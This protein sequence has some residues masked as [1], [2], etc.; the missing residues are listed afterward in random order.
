M[1]MYN[2]VVEVDR[3]DAADVDA[4]MDQLEHHHPAV[5]ISP[6]GWLEARISLPAETLTQACT[7]A[8]LIVEAAT[9]A[10]AI[11]CEVMTEDEFDAREGFEPVPDLLGVTEAAEILGVSRQRIDQLV[12]AGKI[13]SIPVGARSR[14]Y[15]RSSVEAL[16]AQ[17]RSA[18]R[19]PRT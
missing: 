7:T 5:G 18:G 13:Q 14:G 11:A 15:T 3:K 19:P 8:T 17:E 16:A 1:K 12:H 9:G 10:A 4:L 6:R 2:A